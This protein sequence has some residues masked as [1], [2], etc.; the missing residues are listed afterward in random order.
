MVNME[1]RVINKKR[2]TDHKIFNKHSIRS[3]LILKKRRFALQ[4]V[5]LRFFVLVEIAKNE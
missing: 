2:V 1:V 4:C 5:T 3:N